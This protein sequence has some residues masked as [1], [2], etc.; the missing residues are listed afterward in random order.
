M[1]IEATDWKETLANYVSDKGLV[2]G[3][4]KSSQNS[5]VQYQTIQLENGQRHEQ[6]K[7]NTQMQNKPICKDIQHCEP[8]GRCTFKPQWHT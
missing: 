1:K 4:I 8:L 3:S 7:V 5:V 2:S 6:I